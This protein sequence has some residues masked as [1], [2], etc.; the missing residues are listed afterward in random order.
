MRTS[1]S[2]LRCA[3]Y[4]TRLKWAEEIMR[5]IGRMLALDEWARVC[6]TILAWWGV[7]MTS[8]AALFSSALIILGAA[9]SRKKNRCQSRTLD[10]D[11][12]KRMVPLGQTF[13]R[14]HVHGWKAKLRAIPRSQSVAFYIGI[15]S[16]AF[17]IW[18]RVDPQY[19]SVVTRPQSRFDAYKGTPVTYAQ[20]ESMRDTQRWPTETLRTQ[21]SVKLSVTRKNLPK[22]A[23]VGGLKVVIK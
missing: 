1:V 5:E 22:T 12:C 7:P 23:P 4:R 19:P 2:L 13:C 17:A 6:D 9:L 8:Y 11:R 14:Q 18:T 21:D 15:L 10:G 20:L 16:L 3:R